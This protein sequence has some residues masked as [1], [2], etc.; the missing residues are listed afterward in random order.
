MRADVV[1]RVPADDAVDLDGAAELA[2]IL[3]SRVEN[4]VEALAGMRY[5]EDNLTSGWVGEGGGWGE[6]GRGEGGV[7]VGVGLEWQS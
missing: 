1:G 4:T 2:A 7:R 3:G 6:G 5:A